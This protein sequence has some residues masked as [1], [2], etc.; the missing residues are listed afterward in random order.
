MD[1]VA[2]RI[3]L[4]IM[5]NF[6]VELKEAIQ[7]NRNAFGEL[8]PISVLMAASELSTGIQENFPKKSDTGS[9]NCTNFKESDYKSALKTVINR[10]TLK[11]PYELAFLLNSDG[12]QVASQ[13][14]YRRNFAKAIKVPSRKYFLRARDGQTWNHPEGRFFL[15]R[16]FT[17][18]HG[19]YL[20]ALSTQVD[21]GQSDRAG[22]SGCEPKVRVTLGT[23]RS[24]FAT[25]MPPAFGFSVIED[26]TGDV[27]YHSDNSRSLLEN[28]YVETNDDKKLIAAVQARRHNLLSGGYYGESHRFRIEP[29]SFTPWSLVVFYNKTLL[30]TLNFETIVSASAALMTYVLVIF[31]ILIAV[32]LGP[33]EQGWRMFWLQ[34]GLGRCYG[35]LIGVLILSAGLLWATYDDARGLPARL[36]VYQLAVLPTYVL[37]LLTF[38]LDCRWHQKNQR[39]RYRWKRLLSVLGI[40]FGLF[41]IWG[42]EIKLLLGIEG[43]INMKLLFALVFT[44]GIL[45]LTTRF[46]REQKKAAE[47]NIQ[48]QSTVLRRTAIF[49]GLLVLILL[50]AFPA[51]VLFADLS[52]LQADKLAHLTRFH[53]AHQLNRHSLDIKSD[54]QRLDPLIY[55][56]KAG[57]PQY[58]CRGIYTGDLV[59]VSCPGSPHNMRAAIWNGELTFPDNRETGSLALEEDRV[60]DRYPSSVLAENFPPYSQLSAVFHELVFPSSTDGSGVWGEIEGP[61]NKNR[62]TL[63]PPKGGGSMF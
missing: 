31:I 9:L 15:E 33:N 3:S 14:T 34:L 35:Y 7:S 51:Y 25:V 55:S 59:S 57:I 10:K 41:G 56:K 58:D 29:L 23:M 48:R 8:T 52:R 13:K 53:L 54:L 32:H 17:Y 37:G 39:L 43:E 26:A 28:F 22:L 40:A 11:P 44:G 2:G 42:G 46:C 45:T 6:K 16:I 47:K 24:L 1:E 49:S 50:S 36:S 21:S 60:F 30:R 62:Y 5:N 38:F 27:L 20:T 18:D 12:E 61:R 19:L 4:K 63:Y